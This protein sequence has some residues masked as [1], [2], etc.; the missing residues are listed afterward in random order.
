[1]EVNVL[2]LDIGSSSGRG[3]IGRFADGVLHLNEVYRFSNGYFRMLGALY[4]DPINMYKEI[5]NCLRECRKQEIK[6]DCI[7]IDSWAQDYAYLDS[8]GRI[9]GMPRCYHD[10]EIARHAADFDHEISQYD[11]YRHCGQVRCDIS[12]LRQLYFDSRFH[13]DSLR[14]AGKILF[15]PYLLTYMLCGEMGYDC[16][17][18][19]IGEVMDAETGRFS[20]MLA[21]KLG[22]IDKIPPYRECGTII[23]HTG[24]SVCEETGYSGIPVACVGAHDTSAA[25]FAIPALEDEYMFVSSGSF[26]MY[27]T[28]MNK[29]ILNDNA[30]KARLCSSPQCDGKT[31][32]LSGTVGMYIIQQCMKT[33][34]MQG[35]DITYD[36]LTEYALTHESGLIFDFDDI[37][38]SA[39][40]M[41]AEILRVLRLTYNQALKLQEPGDY[42]SVFSES[43]ARRTAMDL[44][45]LEETVGLRYDS[46]YIVGGGSQAAAVNLRLK[47]LIGR[48]IKTGLTEASAA[49][50]A[51]MQLVALGAVQNCGEA[52]A[53]AA[54]SFPFRL[55]G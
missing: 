32:M 46:L 21:T 31:N 39:P 12:T 33:W 14:N 48:P 47:K 36:M 4:W 3:V 44:S 28:I 10:P 20:E 7:A 8:D 13:A 35:F 9:A 16:T 30:F 42:Y 24:Q 52:K 26:A 15:I 40:D 17:L 34:K 54:R 19:P 25:A 1:M 51:L 38:M 29:A 43:L 6:I 45:A 2:A 27:G 53:A 55:V 18:P 22:I 37:D 11:L 49:G 50:N 5:L 23:G 41:P